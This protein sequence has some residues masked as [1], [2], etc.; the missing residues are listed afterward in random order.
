[1]VGCVNIKQCC[2]SCDL[3]IYTSLHFRELLLLGNS[4]MLEVEP[5]GE[6]TTRPSQAPLSRS[7]GQVAAPSIFPSRTVI[8]YR[9]TTHSIPSFSCVKCQGSTGVYNVSRYQSRCKQTRVYTYNTIAYRSSQ[10]NDVANN[11]C[12]PTGREHL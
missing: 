9:F 3:S 8:G 5:T 7:T 2:R 12:R 11:T 4:C 6:V 10:K 1:M